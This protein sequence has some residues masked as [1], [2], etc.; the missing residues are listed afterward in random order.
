MKHKSC[1]I[2]LLSFFLSNYRL[3]ADPGNYYTGLD[4]SKSCAAFKTIL[5]TRIANGAISLSYGDVDAYYNRTDSKPAESG[6]GNVIIDRYSSERPGSLDSC[7]YR[8]DVDFC[9]SG[10]TASVQC[11][12]YVKEHVFPSSWFDD[13]F[14]MRSDMHLLFPADNYTNNTKSNYPLGHVQTANFTSYNGTKIGSSNTSLNF[15]FNSTFVFEPIDEFKGDFA[16]IYLYMITRYET[17]VTGWTFGSSNDVLSGNT[18]PALDPWI[19]QLCIK[20][21]K[22]D[23]PDGLELKRNDS[24]F[25]IQGNR[26]PFVDYPHWAEKVFG[27]NGN[28]GSCISTSVRNNTRTIDYSV[29]PNPVTDILQLK[30][31]NNFTQDLVVELSDILG[32]KIRSQNIQTGNFVPQIDVSDLQ[33]GIYFLNIIY[34]E[35]NN[36]MTFVK[37]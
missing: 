23:L 19:L 34:K 17:V 4:S 6:G 29:Y 32:R 5:A 37:Q 30:L 11:V 12:C 16:R 2:L 8:Y 27:L 21:H 14:P 15:G 22:Q 3:I 33:N 25:A 35:N 9:S 26:N 20:W 18:Y 10:G 7:N 28:S 1:L 36:V 31:K 13:Q 24:I